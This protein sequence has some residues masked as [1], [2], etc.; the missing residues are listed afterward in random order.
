MENFD[1][2]RKKDI[3]KDV[4]E[5]SGKDDV[6]AYV[7]FETE[8]GEEVIKAILHPHAM[9]G[10]LGILGEE[11][12]QGKFWISGYFGRGIRRQNLSWFFSNFWL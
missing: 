9:F 3:Q 8:E 6:G 2:V 5:I 7:D 4:N 1:C 11:R 10:E 12:R